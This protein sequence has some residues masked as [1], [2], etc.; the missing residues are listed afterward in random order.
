MV[1]DLPV[2]LAVLIIGTIKRRKGDQLGRVR[3]EVRCV[4]LFLTLSRNVLNFIGC[5]V[6]FGGDKPWACEGIDGLIYLPAPGIQAG[7][8]A[9]KNSVAD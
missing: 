7:G 5:A 1:T 4:L 6:E 2:N 9:S 8:A 3:G